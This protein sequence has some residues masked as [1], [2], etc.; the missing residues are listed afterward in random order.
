V[1]LDDFKSNSPSTAKLPVRRNVKEVVMKRQPSLIEPSGHGF[2]AAGPPDMMARTD[3]P[4][5]LMQNYGGCELNCLYE[6]TKLEPRPRCFAG[7]DTRCVSPWKPGSARQGPF[8]LEPNI[9][10]NRA[11]CQDL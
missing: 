11:P 2:R 1:G 7:A 3:W 10:S 5:V 8:Q 9:R 4:A 6:Q